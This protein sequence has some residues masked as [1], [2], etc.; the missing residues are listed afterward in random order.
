MCQYEYHPALRAASKCVFMLLAHP[1]VET[2][3]QHVTA[4]LWKLFERQT[5]IKMN[6]KVFYGQILHQ[7]AH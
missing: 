1:H 2:D 6:P 3:I 4:T 5:E 7:T